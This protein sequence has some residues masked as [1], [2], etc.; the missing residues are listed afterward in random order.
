MALP[1]ENVEVH[2]N[3]GMIILDVVNG[4]I[5]CAEVLN[6]VKIRVVLKAA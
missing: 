1:A 5:M 4:K 2:A 3:E 6:S